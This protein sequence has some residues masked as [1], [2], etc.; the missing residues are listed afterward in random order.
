M[1]PAGWKQNS[2]IHPVTVPAGGEVT[3]AVPVIAQSQQSDDFVQIRVTA[4]A[5]GRDLFHETIFTKVYAYVAG[6]L[7]Y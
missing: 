5:E 3:I 2:E 1:L 4:S 7:K 6:Q